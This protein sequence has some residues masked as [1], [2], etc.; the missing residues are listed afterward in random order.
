MVVGHIPKTFSSV[1]KARWFSKG[2]TRDNVVVTIKAMTLQFICVAMVFEGQFPLSH[3]THVVGE[4]RTTRKSRTVVLMV[5]SLTKVAVTR[6]GTAGPRC[7]V[8][9]L[10]CPVTICAVGV[11][12]MLMTNQVLAVM[13]SIGLSITT[14]ASVVGARLSSS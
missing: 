9:G 1:V 10:S 8:V 2:T 12:P 5:V 6:A 7:V 3:S 13:V 4:S 14:L 11:L